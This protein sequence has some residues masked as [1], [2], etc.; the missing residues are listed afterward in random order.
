M[1]K[2]E[3]IIKQ[4]F[5]SWIKRDISIIEKHFSKNVI[6]KEVHEYNG[7]DKIKHE[8]N[9]ERIWNNGYNV[10][11]WDIKRFIKNKNLI[12][13]EWFK[14]WEYIGENCSYDGASIVEFDE[15]DK[16]IIYREFLEWHF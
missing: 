12:V 13:V 4:Y 8:F 6:Y 3:L 2:R 1:N 5:E 9:D 14:E 10:L 16:I 15:N 11:K 7:I